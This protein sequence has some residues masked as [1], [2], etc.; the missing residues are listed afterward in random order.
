MDNTTND[1]ERLKYNRL[2]MEKESTLDDLTRDKRKIEEC[3]FELKDNLHRGFQELN[4]LNEECVR[5]G[6]NENRL[7]QRHNEEQE[8]FFQQQLR[9]A[10]YQIIDDYNAESKSIK[11]ET[12]VLYKKRSEVPWD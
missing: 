1:Q 7:M 12:E 6:S 2:I 8:H 5:N 4:M 9:E 10:E 3:I 11:D